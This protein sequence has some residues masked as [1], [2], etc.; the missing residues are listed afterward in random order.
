[1]MLNYGHI[2]S[3]IRQRRAIA[4]QADQVIAA[5]HAQ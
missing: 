3:R 5:D 2:N 1:M 4:N